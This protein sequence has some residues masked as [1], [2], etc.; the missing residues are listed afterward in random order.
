MDLNQAQ[1]IPVYNRL[2]LTIVSG[3]GCTVTADDGRTFLDLYGGHATALLGYR[4]PKLIETLNRQANE[5][6]FQTN[7]V[8]VP[9]RAK[10][11]QAVGALCQPLDRVFFVNSGAEANENALRLAFRL[12]PGRTKVVVL[13]GGFHGR[14]AAAASCTA[15]HERWYALPRTPFDVVTAPWDQPAVLA[16]LIDSDVAAVIAEPVQGVAGARALSN[17]MLKTLAKRCKNTDAVWISDEVQ[18]GLGRSGHPISGAAAGGMPD[19][20]TLGK[21]IAGGFPCAAV[22]TSARVVADIP[23]GTLGTTFGGGPMATALVAAVLEEVLENNLIE[24]AANLH[25]QIQDT[26]KVGPIVDIQGAGLLV[27]MRTN[28]PAKEVITALRKNGILVGGSADPNVF[29]LM[30]PLTLTSDHVAQFAHALESM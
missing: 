21:G 15:N 22:V 27:G 7:L 16:H 10:A 24:H 25:Q 28:V 8:T 4:H 9:V 30:P 1:E 19:I 20:V 18:C 23:K 5:L 2:G 3:E 26:C 14:T 12:N 29:R 6:F 11:V 17:E 13:E